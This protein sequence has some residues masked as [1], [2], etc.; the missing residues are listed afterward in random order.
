MIFFC[1]QAKLH[2]LQ[3]STAL[4]KNF[5]GS[6]LKKVCL[7]AEKKPLF[8]LTEHWKLNTVA[9]MVAKID[10]DALKIKEN[11]KNKRG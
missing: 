11:I 4:L 7:K 2:L 5:F 10:I 8:E 9:N 3:E 6:R 1:L